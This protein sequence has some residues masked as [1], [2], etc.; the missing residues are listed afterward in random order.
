MIYS[1]NYLTEYFLCFVFKKNQVNYSGKM[2]G[3]LLTTTHFFGCIN[4]L[5]YEKVLE[6][7]D[8]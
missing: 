4:M 7:E 1:Q 2:N 8:I 5:N 6:N 3:L